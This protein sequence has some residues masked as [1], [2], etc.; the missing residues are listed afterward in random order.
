MSVSVV[1]EIDSISSSSSSELALNVT[2]DFLFEISLIFDDHTQKQ[3]K[4]CM[5][6][7]APEMAMIRQVVANV[8]YRFVDGEFEPLT[9][10]ELDEIIYPYETMIFYDSETKMDISFTARNGSFFTVNEFLLMVEQFE[11]ERRNATKYFGGVKINECCFNGLEPLED[12][13]EHVFQLIWSD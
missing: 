6:G 9:S 4:K 8:P 5:I 13:G 7:I 12:R 3:M 2:D 11:L 1:T 10:T